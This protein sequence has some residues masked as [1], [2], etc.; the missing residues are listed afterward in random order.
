M[1]RICSRITYHGDES[2]WAKNME[3]CLKIYSAK[4]RAVLLVGKPVMYFLF[5]LMAFTV[6]HALVKASAVSR[7]DPDMVATWNAVKVLG[8]SLGGGQAGGGARQ[9]RG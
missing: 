9:R 2:F 6:V 3:E 4:E 8:R 1:G 7:P 5:G